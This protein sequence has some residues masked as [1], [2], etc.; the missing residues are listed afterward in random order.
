MSSVSV[1]RRIAATAPPVMSMHLAGDPARQSVEDFIRTVYA[2]RFGADLM[3]FAPMLISLRVGNRLV[4]AAGYRSAG[5][6]RLFLEAYLQAPIERMLAVDHGA[7]PARAR[8]VEVGHLAAA[9]AGE[10]MRLMKML[11]VHLSAQGF[12]WVV[13]TVTEE[14]RHLFGR[15]GIATVV[16]GRADPSALGEPAQRWGRYYEHRPTV[17]AGC[18]PRAVQQLARQDARES[19]A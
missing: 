9:R 19:A 15:L 4:A 8:V 12:H 14:L 7:P 3:H 5:T 2:D 16:L 1:L 13:C 6:E 17:L 10:G 11:G 18:L